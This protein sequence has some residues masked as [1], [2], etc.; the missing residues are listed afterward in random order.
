MKTVD[1]YTNISRWFCEGCGNENSSCLR[2]LDIDLDDPENAELREQM[3]EEGE[4]DDDWFFD[5]DDRD[6][7]EWKRES[8]TMTL[9]VHDQVVT[10]RHCNTKY[11]ANP[12]TVEESDDRRTLK[13]SGPSLDEYLKSDTG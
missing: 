3:I 12:L 13:E 7:E 10:C 6:G 1:L 11:R 5:D 8:M 2:R 4:F 9:W